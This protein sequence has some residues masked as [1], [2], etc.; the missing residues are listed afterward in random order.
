MIILH[1]APH[2]SNIY[3]AMRNR[4]DRCRFDSAGRP[5]LFHYF[6]MPIMQAIIQPVGNAA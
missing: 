5:F 4:L 6:T 3:A 1:D 2:T